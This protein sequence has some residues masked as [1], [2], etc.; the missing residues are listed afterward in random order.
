M[1]NVAP[2]CCSATDSARF[3]E[4]GELAQV[5]FAGPLTVMPPRAL[6]VRALL[7]VG[8]LGLITAGCGP[9]V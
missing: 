6:A 3:V 8:L 7:I 9:P 2:S 1:R 5:E 4:P